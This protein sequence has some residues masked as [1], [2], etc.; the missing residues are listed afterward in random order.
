M[1]CARNSDTESSFHIDSN[2]DRDTQLEIEEAPGSTLF[3]FRSIM[4]S[5]KDI[6]IEKVEGN[7]DKVFHSLDIFN[8]SLEVGIEIMKNIGT[9]SRTSF[10]MSKQLCSLGYVFLESHPKKC[11]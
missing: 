3:P 9:F 6:L 4:L 7:G 5:T 2:V 10:D 11:S 8:N 1:Q